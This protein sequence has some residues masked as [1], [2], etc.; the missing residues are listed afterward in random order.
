[1]LT[2]GVF[3]STCGTI[4]SANFFFQVVFKNNVINKCFIKYKILKLFDIK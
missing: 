4:A 3:V 2:D 1:M